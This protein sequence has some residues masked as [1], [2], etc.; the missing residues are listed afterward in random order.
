MP[1]TDFDRRGILAGGLAATLATACSGATGE[2]ASR[3]RRRAPGADG[4]T[5]DPRSFGARGD[6]RTDDTSAFQRAIDSAAQAGEA[7][8]TFGPGTY[9]V[10][11]QRSEDGDGLTGLTMR[12]GV[13]LEG[14]DR[15]RCILRLADGQMGPGTYARLI[16]SNGEIARATLRRFTI[17]GNRQGQGRFRDD[18][19]GAAVLLGWKARCVGVTVED[20]TVRDAIGQGIMLQ[21]STDNLS[22]DL[23]ITRNLVE[24]SSYIGIQCSQFDGVVISDN[25]VRDCGDNGIDIY[26]DDTIGHSPVATS[27]HATI[28]RNEVRGCSIGIFLETVADSSATDNIVVGC[29]STG[30]R[31]NRIHG[32]PRNL[33]I[34]RNRIVD[35]PMGVAMGGET[36]GV[37]IRDNTI[38]G[39]TAAAIDFQY[40][41]SNVTVSGNRFLP[42]TPTTFIV[43][44]T[45]TVANA[46][47]PQRLLRIRV[48]GNRIPRDHD[49]KRLFDNR[50]GAGDVIVDGF[51][52]DL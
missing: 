2:Q 35:T 16:G 5:F 39:F 28:V 52:R 25:N 27:H 38:S 32:E 13:V 3:D 34:A 31:I 49:P 44:G 20:L 12:S 17:D 19:S 37:V 46:K 26:G 23:R 29:R 40:N 21:G 33:T 1:Q 45:P 51:A 7:V 11:Y 42:A 41:V 18:L 36:G 24:R 43:A 10:R 6:G 14:T 9:L 4:R 50:Y 47:P 48:Q 8:V 22:R 30:V 15:A